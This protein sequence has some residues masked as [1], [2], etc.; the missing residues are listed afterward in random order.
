VTPTL[1]DSDGPAGQAG[2]TQAQTQQQQPQ[3]QQRLRAQQQERARDRPACQTQQERARGRP[4]GQ[5][6]QERG[7]EVIRELQAEAKRQRM[8]PPR[9][10]KE[11]SLQLQAAVEAVAARAAAAAAAAGVG[12][13]LEPVAMSLLARHQPASTSQLNGWHKPGEC[14]PTGT[15]GTPSPASAAGLRGDDGSLL[16]RYPWRSLSFEPAGLEQD[17]V[18]HYGRRQ[19]PVS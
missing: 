1:S 7:S 10:A 3:Q 19:E 6:Q 15:D 5:A 4:A 12:E 14:S 13:G 9:T 11:R 2:Q 8:G 17:F 18:R 16:A